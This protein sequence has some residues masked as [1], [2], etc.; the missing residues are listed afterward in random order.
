MP[1]CSS[2]PR[3][4]TCSR[5]VYG[6]DA[7]AIADIFAEWKTGELD[8]YLIEITAAVLRKRD[9]TGEALVDAILDEAE[10]K[11]TGRWTAQSALDLGV[12]LTSITEAVF[13]RALSAAARQRVAAEEAFWTPQMCGRASAG[14]AEIDAIR[15]ALYA[16]KIVAYAQGFEQMTA[17]SRGI[18]LE[19]EARRDRDDLARRLHHPRPLPRP[20]PRSL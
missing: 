10:Q 20:H 5:S 13:A 15:D 3:P 12:P 2:S 8:S 4:T 11:G 19:A 1:T 7:A 14:K 6:L 17:A 9:A 16:S 18:R